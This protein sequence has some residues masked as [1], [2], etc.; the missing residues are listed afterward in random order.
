MVTTAETAPRL[1]CV[2]LSWN[3]RNDTLAC[4]KSLL[5]S[6]YDGLR[7]V[8]VDNA[9]TDGSADAV[10]AAFP[11]IP[12]IE[13][14]EN[15]RWAGGNNV[16]IRYAMEQGADYILLLNNDIEVDAEM[17]ARLAQAASELPEAGILAPKIYYAAQPD[18]IWYAGGGVSLWRGLFWHDGIR[19]KDVGQ[20]EKARDVDYITGCA[21]LI[22]RAVLEQIGELDE[23]FYLYGEDVDYSLR[24]KA[25][26]YR[27]RLVPGATMRHKVSASLGPTSLRKFLIRTRSNLRL[28]RKYAPVWSWFT[29]I[30]IFAV[31]DAVRAA[32]LLVTGK[33]SRLKS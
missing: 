31:L 8:V 17:I 15:L 28:Y 23:R 9:S 4:L 24:A 29:T 1:W 26:G 7:I 14:S 11:D 33:L 16:G 2:V 22:R 13:N 19:E 12:L 32:L 27:L 6:R 5:L 21:M 18:V 3:G 10:R 30:P 25:S 20:F